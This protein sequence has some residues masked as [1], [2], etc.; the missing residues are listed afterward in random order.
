M[1]GRV[2]TRIFNPK[3]VAD[4]PVRWEDSTAAAAQSYD[5]SAEE[6]ELVREQLRALGYID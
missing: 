5:Y 1:D 6:A 2:L 3:Y 4:H